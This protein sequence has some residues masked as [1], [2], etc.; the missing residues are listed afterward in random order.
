M[1]LQQITSRQKKIQRMARYWPS[2]RILKKN[3]FENPSVRRSKKAQM[4]GPYGVESTIQLIFKD[5]KFT[6]ALPEV[7]M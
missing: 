4:Y 2:S 7:S 6:Y 3:S 5:W 1:K